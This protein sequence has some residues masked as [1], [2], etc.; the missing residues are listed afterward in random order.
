MVCSTLGGAY[1]PSTE[2]RGLL[3][4]LALGGAE[5]G[6]NEA[7]PIALGHLQAHGLLAHVGNGNTARAV[8]A[9]ELDR[10]GHGAKQLLVGASETVLGLEEP[11]LEIAV[12]GLN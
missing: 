5:M 10:Q 3:P 4:D 11:R 7:S 12:L 1:A 9:L 6:E 2:V 8:A